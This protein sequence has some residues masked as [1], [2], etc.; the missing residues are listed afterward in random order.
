M[1]L[2]IRLRTHL[3]LALALAVL[4]APVLATASNASDAAGQGHTEYKKKKFR[5]AASYFELAITYNPTHA[6]YYYWA[7]KSHSGAMEDQD[8]YE[9]ILGALSLDDADARYHAQHAHVCQFLGNPGEAVMAFEKAFA[10]GASGG[11]L[12]A[13]YGMV[14]KQSGHPYQA[15]EAYRKALSMQPDLPGVAFALGQSLMELQ[16]PQ[17][18]VTAFRQAVATDPRCVDCHLDLGD[19]LLATGNSS[20]ALGAYADVIRLSPEDYRPRQRSIQA[21]FALSDF[22]AARVHER[23]LQ[24]LYDDDKVYALGGMQAYVVDVFQVRDLTVKAYQYYDGQA[25]DGIQWTFLAFDPTGWQERELALRDAVAVAS[26]GRKATRKSG[27]ELVDI[28][29]GQPPELLTGWTQKVSYPTVRTTVIEWL[30]VE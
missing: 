28:R 13:D 9:W 21:C 29:E 5:E 12:Y 18:A 24:A 17:Q 8:A 25:P 27:V 19:A 15:M 3:L 26:A 22:D 10:R 30:K 6:E 2:L 7:S 4:S 16:D 14:L 1:H 20:A 23:A 11:Q